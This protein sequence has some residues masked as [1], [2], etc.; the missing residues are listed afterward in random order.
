MGQEELIA[1]LYGEADRKAGA[2]W[3]EARAEADK[4][5]RQGDDKLRR[6][7]EEISR[8]RGGAENEEAAE[9]LRKADEEARRIR[10]GAEH[11]LSE[12]LREAA[13][14]SVSGL[15]GEGYAETFRALAR[16]LPPFQW[17]KVFVNPRD[18]DMAGEL[19][20]EAETAGRQDIAGGMEVE[21]ADSRVRVV[22]TFLKRLER[23]WPGLLPE[24]I[25]SAEKAAGDGA[26]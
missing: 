1:S 3:E 19:F 10:L 13:S 16:E 9:V 18:V 11:R 6:R 5:R 14:A 12:R 20:P 15:R 24:L 25:K 22:N 4:I 8:A 21:S 7:K 2:L 17:K 23:A 26:S